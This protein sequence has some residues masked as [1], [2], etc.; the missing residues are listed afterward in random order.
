MKNKNAFA[1]FIAAQVVW[2]IQWLLAHQHYVHYVISPSR[3]ALLTGAVITIVLLIG[4]DGIKGGAQRGLAFIKHIWTGW[5][6]DFTPFVPETE[7]TQRQSQPTVEVEIDQAKADEMN[8]TLVE[9]A[10][11]Q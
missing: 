4:K 2:S 11:E 7:Q 5:G 1:A 9:A 6:N 3:Q 10:A 8:N